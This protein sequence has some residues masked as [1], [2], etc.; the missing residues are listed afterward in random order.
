LGAGSNI[1]Q[2]RRDRDRLGFKYV[3]KKLHKDLLTEKPEKPLDGY[4]ILETSGVEL[5]E[6]VFKAVLN[7]KKC[8]Y[9]DVVREHMDEFTQLSS[10]DLSGHRMQ[11]SSLNCFPAVKEIHLSCNNLKQ[12]RLAVMKKDIAFQNLTAL[13][14]S[15]NAVDPESF[16]ELGR[17]PK[18]QFL[19]LSH[20]QL[21]SLPVLKKDSF[22]AL[23]KLV[24]RGNRLGRVQRPPEDELVLSS[25]AAYLDPES[26]F[27]KPHYTFFTTL[28]GLPAL[29]DL[30]LSSNL[31]QVIPRLPPGSF[32]QLRQI[33]L[34]INYLSR[35]SYLFPVLSCPMLKWLDIRG[36]MFLPVS[37]EEEQ[38]KGTP[39]HQL[40]RLSRFD[41]PGLCQRLRRNRRGN[42]VIMDPAPND[43]DEYILRADDIAQDDYFAEEKSADDFTK[44]PLQIEDPTEKLE[45]EIA[46]IGAEEDS[47]FLTTSFPDLNLGNNQKGRRRNGARALDIATASRE[48]VVRALQNAIKRPTTSKIKDPKEHRKEGKHHLSSTYAQRARRRSRKKIKQKK[49]PST[50]GGKDGMALRPT[51][52]ALENIISTV[53]KTQGLRSH[54]SGSATGR[55]TSRQLSSRRMSARSSARQKEDVKE[56]YETVSKIIS[57]P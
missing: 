33:N 26:K 53:R 47:T 16:L 5:P 49:R 36:N 40:P 30:D 15:Y 32:P 46:E 20:N 35:E 22:P 29:H 2:K 1:A 12:I 9:M 52:R 6:E 28:A 21:R 55:T 10:I 4:D 27:F 42:V 18:L 51:I 14:L 19:D 7:A 24:L 45:R 56:I 17:L 57:L 38:Q 11:L 54:R 3:P 43:G 25:R 37:L 8:T 13:D 41:F 44:M 23:K 50:T 34:S 48:Q 31:I 39:I